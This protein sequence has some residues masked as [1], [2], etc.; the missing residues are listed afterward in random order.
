[1]EREEEAGKLSEPEDA[2][3][4]EDAE[5]GVLRGVDDTETGAGGSEMV[6]GSLNGPEKVVLGAEPVV[7]MSLALLLA[8]VA[9]EGVAE[10]ERDAEA[11][12]DEELFS[13]VNVGPLFPESPNTGRRTQSVQNRVGRYIWVLTDKEIFPS[14]HIRRHYCN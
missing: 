2:K 14:G 10:V 3:D 9:D 13:I 11:E 8:A 7:S 12:E 5:E 1:M 6:L 4:A